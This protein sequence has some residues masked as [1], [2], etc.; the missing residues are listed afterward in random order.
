[1]IGIRTRH[2]MIFC[3][4]NISNARRIENGAIIGGKSQQRKM[5]RS[6]PPLRKWRG[7]RR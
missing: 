5:L 7:P 4:K 6:L 1:M 2:A 3:T